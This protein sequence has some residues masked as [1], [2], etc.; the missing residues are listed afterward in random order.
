MIRF[1][2]VTSQGNSEFVEAD[3]FEITEGVLYFYSVQRFVMAFSL[4][5]WISFRAA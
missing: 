2:I 3:T 1:R 4:N 5:G